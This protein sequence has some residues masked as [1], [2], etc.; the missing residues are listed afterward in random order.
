MSELAPR[1]AAVALRSFPRRYR[2]AFTRPGDQL[3]DEHAGRSGSSGQTPFDLA[4]NTVR[5][6]ALLERALEQ[7][8]HT[9][10]PVLHAAVTNPAAREFDPT[11]HGSLDDV[12]DE[13]GQVSP[14]FADRV[15]RMHGDEWN[16]PATITGGRD[17]TALAVLQEA[18]RTA[19][20]NLRTIESLLAELRT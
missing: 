15:D 14:A 3:D 6:L 13:L 19:S 18:V 12:L 1:D 5:T 10:G 20:D 2:E 16:R 17:T 7:I 8:Q 9:D 4:V 11:V